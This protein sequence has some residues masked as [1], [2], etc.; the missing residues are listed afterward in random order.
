M[1]KKPSR[2]I[3]AYTRGPTIVIALIAEMK[4]TSIIKLIASAA[5][6]PS[7]RAITAW[8]SVT[9]S[10]LF[11]SEAKSEYPKT[12]VLEAGVRLATKM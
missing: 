4:S 8:P 1:G 3:A 11:L 5:S 12:T 2:A 9:E 7:N 6:G 10:P